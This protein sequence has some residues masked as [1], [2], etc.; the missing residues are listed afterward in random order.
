[1][2]KLAK[3]GKQSY[4]IARIIDINTSLPFDSLEWMPILDLLNI[5][6]LRF[7]SKAI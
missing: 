6:I 4:L 3:A 7:I 5:S 2:Q 1:L